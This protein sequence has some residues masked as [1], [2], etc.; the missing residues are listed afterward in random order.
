MRTDGI[1]VADGPQSESEFTE[2]AE[3]PELFGCVGS[4]VFSCGW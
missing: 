2:L 4:W 3:F 1:V